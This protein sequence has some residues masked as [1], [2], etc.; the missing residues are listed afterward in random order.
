[1]DSDDQSSHER[2]QEYE[3]LAERER[4]YRAKKRVALDDVGEELTGVVERAIATAGANVTVDSTSSDGH[5]Q[6]L[7]PRLDKAALV[8]AVT[9][10]L[11]DGFAVKSV[12][13]DGTLS[14]EW[15]RR[16]TS[17]EKRA[18]V[19]LQA[20]VAEAVVTDADELI[21]E[22]PTRS[23]VVER[24]TELGVDRELAG[25]RLQRLD[26]IGK[27]DIEEGQVFPG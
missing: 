5:T 13:D 9:D 24:A 7:R 1:M 27:V 19:I 8:A 15:S 6:R 10:E 3:E 23:A 14:V 16:E 25:E 20:I 22:A 11:P 18:M 21:V 26:D 2:M 4:E 12:N 17:A